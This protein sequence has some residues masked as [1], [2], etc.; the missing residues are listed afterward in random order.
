MTPSNRYMANSAQKMGVEFEKCA[1][2]LCCKST[3][4]VDLQIENAIVGRLSESTRQ[5]E[6][7]ITLFLVETESPLSSGTGSTYI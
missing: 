7:L 2:F 5:I 4:L 6:V 1:F 3:R